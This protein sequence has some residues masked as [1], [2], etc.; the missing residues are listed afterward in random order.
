DPGLDAACDRYTAYFGRPATPRWARLETQSLKRLDEVLDGDLVRLANPLGSSEG[1]I[2]RVANAHCT[3]LAEACQRQ[4]S[5]R[6][7]APVMVG[8][9]PWGADVRAQFGILRLEFSVAVGTEDEARAALEAIM[10]VT[11]AQP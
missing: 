8:V 11:L 7:Q 3:E 4:T 6:P 5:T 9:D 1:R 2:C 10:G